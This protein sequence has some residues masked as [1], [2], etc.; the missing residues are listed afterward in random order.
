MRNE[1]DKT[2]LIVKILIVVVIL[3]ALIV[4]YLVVFQQQYNNFVAQKQTEGI[5]LF[6]SQYLI[7]QLQQNGYVSI[8]IGNQT[9]YLVPVV[10][11]NQTTQGT[12]SGNVSTNT[13]Q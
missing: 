7:P 12:G 11:G 2:K 13:T 5:N 1:N 10:P 6:I 4:L 9:L 8:P 3:L